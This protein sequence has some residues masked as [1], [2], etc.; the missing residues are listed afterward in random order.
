MTIYTCV[1]KRYTNFYECMKGFHEF[2]EEQ[3]VDYKIISV[4]HNELSFP[5]FKELMDYIHI[6]YSL[7]K[8]YRKNLIFHFLEFDN[9]DIASDNFL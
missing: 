1:R 6:K 2:S 3:I 8:E 9:P 4:P 7:P 5:L